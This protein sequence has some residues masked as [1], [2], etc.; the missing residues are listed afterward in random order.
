VGPSAPARTDLFASFR[1][2][3]TLGWVRSYHERVAANED[4]FRK[5]N[6]MLRLGQELRQRMFLLCE[7]GDA[8]CTQSIHMG[9]EDYERLRGHAGR[10]AIVR[11]HEV[12]DVE[13]VV[14]KCDGYVTVEKT[15]EAGR[16]AV[17]RDPR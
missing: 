5:R 9:F 15:G 4:A 6:E 13:S 11:G 14:E 16:E 12:L 2:L 8:D 7:C 10:F 3:A 17:R 1:D